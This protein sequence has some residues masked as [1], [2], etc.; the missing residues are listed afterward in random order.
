MRL[1]ITIISLLL[2]V[3]TG[4]AWDPVYKTEQ[5][6]GNYVNQSMI[7]QLE[8]GM[9][10]EQVQFVMGT[11]L[12]VDAYHPNRWHYLY[13][14]RDKKGNYEE[15]SMILHFEDNR[16]AEMEGTFRPE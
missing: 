8:P 14:L 12:V 10:Q 1:R 13:R 15:K 11:P 4:C 7:N 9:T 3:L 6:Q 2:G 16:L 5:H